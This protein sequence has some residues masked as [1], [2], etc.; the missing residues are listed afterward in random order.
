MDFKHWY[1]VFVITGQEELVCSRIEQGIASRENLSAKL[2]VPKRIICERKDGVD[3]EV[4]RVMF[5]GY[6]LVGTDQIDAVSKIIA[7]A[8]GALSILRGEDCY[9][10]IRLEEISRLVYMADDEG[11]IGESS[12]C[13]NE[14]N[15]I[16]VLTGPLKGEEGRIVKFDRR[17]N[18]VAVEFLFGTKKHEIWFGVR[19]NSKS[20]VKYQES[21]P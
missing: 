9:L 16:Q 3:S 12:V 15:R 10:E 5:P 8:T 7:N 4:C 20:R 13:L 6:V 14:E 1:A 19:L 18:R 17:R 11:V 21:P 2:F